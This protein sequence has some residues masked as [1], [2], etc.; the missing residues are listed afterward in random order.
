MPR[1]A[2]SELPSIIPLA[3]ARGAPGGV[4]AKAARGSGGGGAPTAGVGAAASASP[5]A[6]GIVYVGHVPHGFYEGQLRSYLSQFG[7]LR[8]VY[9]SRSRRT[10]KSRGYAFVQFEDALVARIAAETLHG[11]PLGGKVLRAHVVDPQK[12]HPLLFAFA[13]RKWTAIPWRRLVREL[14]AA[15]KTGAAAAKKLRRALTREA[16]QE[17]KLRAAGI[18]YEA[19]SSFRTLA[20]KAGVVGE[21]EEEEEDDDDECEEEEEEEE[22]SAPPPPK[23]APSG[24]M[25]RGRDAAQAPRA[26]GKPLAG[27]GSAAAEANAATAHTEKKTAAPAKAEA[28]A[29]AGAPAKAAKLA[30][31]SAAAKAAAP[32]LAKV[33]VASAPAKA[34]AASTGTAS[35]PAPKA[36][37]AKKQK[38]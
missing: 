12:A 14:Q 30:M 28:P 6:A 16:A 26:K 38:H 23:A 31:P 2:P 29:K 22:E 32:A 36:A 1:S 4:V 37:A 5:D 19:P 11:Y 33:A 20:L 34:G 3:A 10:G 15:P 7:A 9:L 18:E 17:A 24:A 8:H 13:D 35:G 21:E 27:K 25:K